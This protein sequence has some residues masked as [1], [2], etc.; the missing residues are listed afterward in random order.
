MPTRVGI[1]T[2][3]RTV[4]SPEQQQPFLQAARARGLSQSKISRFLAENPDDYHRLKDVEADQPPTPAAT[5]A[6]TLPTQGAVAGLAGG[7]GAPIGTAP[8]IGASPLAGLAAAGPGGGAEV[9]MPTETEFTPLGAETLGS[10][11]LRQYLGNRLYPQESL[12][13]AGLRRVY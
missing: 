5:P 2:A 6:Q 8:T 3:E 7:G 1:G 11:A 13:L 4:Y 9:T 10:S 12:V